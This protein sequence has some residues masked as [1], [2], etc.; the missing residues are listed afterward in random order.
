MRK[1]RQFI[2]VAREVFG[3]REAVLAREITKIHEEFIRGNLDNLA[4]KIS[5]DR[6]KGE[7]TILIKGK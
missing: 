5:E 3:P 6:L 2:E 4:S 1:F 7:A